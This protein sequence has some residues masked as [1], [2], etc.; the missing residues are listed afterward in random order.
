MYFSGCVF[1]SWGCMRTFWI[2]YSSQER[3]GEEGEGNSGY[4]LRLIKCFLFVI[5]RCGVRSLPPQGILRLDAPEG[6]VRLGRALPPCG[7]ESEPC[8]LPEARDAR[9]KPGALCDY[10]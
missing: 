4:V 3:A 1:V 10:F 8:A 7:V 6:S 9:R 2:Q 5:F